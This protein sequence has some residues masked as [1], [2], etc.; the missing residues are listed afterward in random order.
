MTRNTSGIIDT[1]LHVIDMGKL[2]YP[3]LAGFE[4]LRRDYLV[5]TYE[6]EARRCGITAALH[7]EVD[8][9]ESDIEAETSMVEGFMARN[10]GLVIGAISSCRPENADFQSMLERTFQN[11]A[12]KGLRRVLHVMPDQ[13][14]TTALFRDN[15][16]RLSKTG[17]PFDLCVLPHQ[18]PLAIALA[19]HAP[20]VQFVLDHCGV[21]GIKDKALEPWANHISEI[22]KRPNVAVKISGVSAYGDAAK[23]T[24]ED[25]RPFVEHAINAF[26]WNRCVWGG[27]WPVVTLGSSLSTWVAATHALID[28]CS[29]SEKTA[30]LS[31]NAKR[32]WG[33]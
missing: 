15:V 18:I 25:L 2:S 4:P 23:W 28:G 33:L 22:A 20:D 11:K 10:G 31:G 30:L 3:W 8:V 17:L 16:K 14:S 5:E 12:V 9:A 32:I 6:T 26:G 13:L 19:D 29:A 24:V 21:P 1:H 27:D 7:M